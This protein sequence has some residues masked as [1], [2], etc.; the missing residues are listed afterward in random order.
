ML[1]DSRPDAHAD[2]H[3]SPAEQ[4]EYVAWVSAEVNR[5]D[6]Y[7][8]RSEPL[9]HYTTGQ[10]AI[11]II[12][13][14][15]LWATQVGCLNDTTELTHA[16]TVLRRMVDTLTRDAN[17][18]TERAFFTKWLLV[19]EQPVGVAASSPFFVACF[20]E[21]GD[22]LSQWR[23]YGGGEGGIALGFRPQGLVAMQAEPRIL[24]PVQYDEQEQLEAAR[25]VCEATFDFYSRHGSRRDETVCATWETEF[26]AAWDIQL[27]FLSPVFKNPAFKAEREWR[28]IKQVFPFEFSHLKFKQ[29]QSMISRHIPLCFGARSLQPPRLP[30]AAVRI[31]PSKHKAETEQSV[32]LMLMANGYDTSQIEVSSSPIPFQ[33]H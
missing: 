10:G 25:R 12:G 27:S 9:W 6:R 24:L 28:I 26:R 15:T 23:A 4:Q 7:K 21:D 30:L 22:D 14:G 5:Y 32:R 2:S 18:D 19:F 16:P 8:E 3:V 11:D 1:D 31:G 20:S 13:S 29:R 17:T 33:A